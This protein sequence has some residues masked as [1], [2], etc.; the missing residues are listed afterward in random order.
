M[1]VGLY[2]LI[3]VLQV[4]ECWNR[5]HSQQGWFYSVGTISLILLSERFQVF[6]RIITARKQSWGKVMFLHLS[7]ILFTEG[8]VSQQEYVCGLGGVCVTGVCA[9]Q[10][11]VTGDVC[12][13]VVWQTMCVTGVCDRVWWQREVYNPIPETHSPEPKAATEVGSMHLTAMLFYFEHFIP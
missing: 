10:G 5:I 1:V 12:N 3:C 6:E 11:C 2:F 7:V 13:R 8:C 4:K 9:C